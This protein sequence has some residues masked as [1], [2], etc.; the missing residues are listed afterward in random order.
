MNHWKMV[1]QQHLGRFNGLN[2]VLAGL[3]LND[4]SDRN[5]SVYVGA[6]TFDYGTMLHRDP[7]NQ[8]TYQSVGNAANILA[9]RISYHFNL[10]GP[11]VAID[12]ACSSSLT[13]LHLACQSLRTG[14]SEQA[15][16]SGTTLILG[17]ENMSSLSSLR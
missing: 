15:I 7:E 5:I 4:I 17:P 9:N 2:H 14:E 16:V 6:S 13:V 12:T 1:C 11:S 3:A 10:K 8:P